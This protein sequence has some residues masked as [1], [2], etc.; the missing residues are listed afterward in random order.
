MPQAKTRKT[1]STRSSTTTSK[2]SSASSSQPRKT[3]SRRKPVEVVEDPVEVVEVEE[4]VEDDVEDDVDDTAN[5][6]A[7]DTTTVKPARKR[8]VPTAESLAEQGA[9][10]VDLL[11]AEIENLKNSKERTKGSKF[12]RTVLKNVKAYNTSV[13]RFTKR[14]PR[15][16]AR[17][18]QTNSIFM[19][20]VP[21]SKELARFGN[22][23]PNELKSR[24]DVTKAICEYIAVNN[25][26][27][28]SARKHIIPDERLQR[29]LNYDPESDE[30][31]TYP[32]LQKFLKYHY[33]KQE[34]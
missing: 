25:L 31:L 13:D 7:S 1:V 12:L 29:L 4:V 30:P 23:D 32:R 15:S 11:T 21:I 17:K 14:K 22:W 19:K 10:L 2:R 16:G 9:N 24:T 26:Q 8:N 33:P 28:P 34:K 6:S 3:A 5:D 27:D 20:P 18:G